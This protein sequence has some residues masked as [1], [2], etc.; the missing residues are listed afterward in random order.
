M[1]GITR[2]DL[3]ELTVRRGLP[4]LAIARV[5]GRTLMVVGLLVGGFVVHQL[6]IT[7]WAAERAQSGLD[8]R[9]AAQAAT[10]EIAE[11]PYEPVPRAASPIAV[12]LPTFDT[13]EAAIAVLPGED[14]PGDPVATLMIEPVPGE[15]EPV[16]RISIP[17][18]GIEWTFV[19]GVSRA[20]LRSGHSR[21]SPYARRRR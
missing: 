11:V 4:V 12:D 13:A 2:T 10:V 14:L 8:E 9:F 21:R 19:E 15:G 16:G 3:P 5:L 7:S 20:A 1:Q 6:V 17:S 18:A